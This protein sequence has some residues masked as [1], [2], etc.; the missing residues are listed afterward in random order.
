[1]KLNTIVSLIFV[2][3]LLSATAFAQQTPAA[4]LPTA[5]Q[6][7]DKYVE[8]IGGRAANEKIKTRITKS[9]LELSPM[10]VTGTEET[11]SA[12]PNKFYNVLNLQGVGEVKEGYDGTNGWS[13]DPIQGSRPK[14]GDEL[15]QAK[16]VS[17]FYR[18]INLDKLYSNWEVKGIEKVGD[19]DAYVVIGTPAGLAPETFYFDVQNGL[20]LQNDSTLV[21]P[22]G[23]M[24]GKTFFEDYRETDGVKIPYKTRV[25]LP[26]FEVISTVTEVKSNEKIDDGKFAKP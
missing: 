20:L 23:K 25:V 2:V 9:T 24:A 15:A 10:G 7:F 22:Q 21:S 13:T 18:D 12:A 1:M 8:A 3:L 6:I 26:Q 14:E 4:K 5:Q 19:R 11:Y 17:N 16:L